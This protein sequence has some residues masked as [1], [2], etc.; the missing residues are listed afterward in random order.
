[1]LADGRPLFVVEVEEEAVA[2][3]IFAGLKLA[4]TRIWLRAYESVA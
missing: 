2:E 3:D 4:A 1:M